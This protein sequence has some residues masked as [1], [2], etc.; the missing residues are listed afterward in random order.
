MAYFRDLRDH[1]AAL[2]KEG[3]L[4]RIDDHINKDT[5]LMPLV[6]W[7]FRGLPEE[8]RRAFLFT[9]VKDV[10]GN[11]SGPSEDIKHINYELQKDIKELLQEEWDRI[12][13]GP[14]TCLNWGS[15]A[16]P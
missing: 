4:V 5:E 11:R 2:N 1:V 13:G 8:E 12:C 6:R 10:K 16:I 9:D 7:Q 15:R 14:F 3:L